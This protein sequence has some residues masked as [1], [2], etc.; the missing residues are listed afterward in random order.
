MIYCV[1]HFEVGRRKHSFIYYITLL[2]RKVESARPAWIFSRDFNYKHIPSSN[3]HVKEL[4]RLISFI[5]HTRPNSE[6]TLQRKISEDA[7]YDYN[8]NGK[9]NEIEWLFQILQK[10]IKL[11]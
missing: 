4:K 10:S 1:A 3:V 7:Q 9:Y 11:F 5:G 2:D 8:E 6:G